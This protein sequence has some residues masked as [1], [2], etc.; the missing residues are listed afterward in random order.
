MELFAF[1]LGHFYIVDFFAAEHLE[2]ESVRALIYYVIGTYMTIRLPSDFFDDA[3]GSMSCR[4][5]DKGRMRSGE[6]L[7]IFSSTS[8]FS[9]SAIPA[10][11]H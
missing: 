11:S 3:E 7:P 5:S 2:R 9:G 4:R 10:S 1:L 8:Y 6:L